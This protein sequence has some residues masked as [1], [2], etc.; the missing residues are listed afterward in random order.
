MDV[1]AVERVCMV[2]TIT[3]PTLTAATL[4]LKLVDSV[5]EDDDAQT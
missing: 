4:R 3:H 5:F 2:S 1:A